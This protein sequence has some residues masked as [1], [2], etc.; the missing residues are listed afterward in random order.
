M[1]V[2]ETQNTFRSSP[3]S[4]ERVRAFVAKLTAG[5]PRSD[6][7]VLVADELATNALQH[8]GTEQFTVAVDFKDDNVLVAVSAAPLTAT[9]PL[10]CC[11][12]IEGRGQGEHGRGLIIVASLSKSWGCATVDG[13]QVVYATLSRHPAELAAFA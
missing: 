7:A 8:T 5:H 3:Q 13:Q 6:D 11:D 9:A 2:T 4:M 12:G 10:I 1:T